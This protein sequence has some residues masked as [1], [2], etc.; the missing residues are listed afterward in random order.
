MQ[1]LYSSEI[2]Q[3]L[4]VRDATLSL[5]NSLLFLAQHNVSILLSDETFGTFLIKSV[6]VMP[7]ENYFNNKTLF[8]SS[9]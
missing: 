9:K 2:A 7:E 4:M 1:V 8:M 5:A 3:C 6:H